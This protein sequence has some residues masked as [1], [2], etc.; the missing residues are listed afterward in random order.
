MKWG[1]QAHMRKGCSE[2][3]LHDAAH[4]AA[5]NT[6]LGPLQLAAMLRTPKGLYLQDDADSSSLVQLIRRRSKSHQALV[7]DIP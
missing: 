7:H 1:A 2:T 4:W 6:P 3:Q 5:A